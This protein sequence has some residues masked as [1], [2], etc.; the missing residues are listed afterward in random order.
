[1]F[2]GIQYFHILSLSFK[3]I[4]LRNDNTHVS[5]LSRLF[6]T[7][8]VCI[9]ELSVQLAAPIFVAHFKFQKQMTRL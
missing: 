9:N 7:L 6:E 3:A 8:S 4:V 2:I 1:M 5:I